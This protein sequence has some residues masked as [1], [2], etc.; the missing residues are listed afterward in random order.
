MA[1]RISV[2]ETTRQALKGY[3]PEEYI[4][5]TIRLQNADVVR[6]LV[7]IG[8]VTRAFRALPPQFEFDI[9]LNDGELIKVTCKG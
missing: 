8:K 9:H 6:G 5:W 7:V 4:P 2:I 3:K 1:R